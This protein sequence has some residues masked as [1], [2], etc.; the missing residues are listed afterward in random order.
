[1]GILMRNEINYSGSGSSSPSAAT[2]LSELTDVEITSLANGQGLFYNEEL[3]KWVNGDVA[4]G[5]TTT[6]TLKPWLYDTENEVVIGVYNGKPLYRK[7]IKITASVSKSGETI[8][9]LSD[10]ILNIDKIVSYIG[11]DPNGTVLPLIYAS[12]SATHYPYQMCLVITVT[13]QIRISAGDDVSY[14]DDSIF[15][16]MIEYTKT[17]DAEDSGTNLMPYSFVQ[18]GGGGCSY[19]TEE[20][21]IGKWVNGKPLYQKT[22]YIESLPN[23]SSIYL[24]YDDYDEVI[25]ITGFARHKELLAWSIPLPYTNDS[26]YNTI[27]DIF[28]EDT[29]LPARCVRIMSP[30][31]DR[32]NM[33]GYVTIQYTKTTDSTA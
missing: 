33:Y 20:Q 25:S 3:Q 4:S 13:N 26:G 14:P 21:V 12:T 29:S 10:Y 27:I 8:I 9:A 16:I 11:Y 17:T 32:S 5:D 19:S 15:T 22:I 2:S 7:Y 18:T 24:A 28:T 31:V 1:M 6:G 23:Y 30:N